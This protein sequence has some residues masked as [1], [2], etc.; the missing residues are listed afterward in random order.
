MS[1]IALPRVDPLVPDGPA[2]KRVSP[3]LVW[4]LLLLAP[5]VLVFLVFVVYPV[6]YGLWLARDPQS[7]VKLMDDPV[8]FRSILNTTIFLLV[9]VNLKFILAMVVSGLLVQSRWWIKILARA[10][11]PAV[12]GAV[13]P[14]DPVVPFHVQSRVGGHQHADLPVHRRRRPELAQQ[15]HHR[16][17]RGDARPHLE[18]AAILDADPDR[19]PPGDP[20]RAIRGR[21]RR[22]RRRRGRSSGSSPGPRCKRST[23]LRHCCR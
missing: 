18:V 2:K 13:D 9:A 15:S 1:T 11:H 7:Y 10:V 14:D 19:W 5:Y 21:E 22:R 4:G 8:F 23:S 20:R 6:L 3:W 12:G 17:L 16:A